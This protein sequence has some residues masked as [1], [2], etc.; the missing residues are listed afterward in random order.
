MEAITPLRMRAVDNNC[1]YLG[2][3]PLQLMEN[4]GAGIAREISSQT[5]AATVLFIAGRGN[6]D[7]KSVV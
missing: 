4:A 1:F 6:K 2:M 3:N 5:R 7:R